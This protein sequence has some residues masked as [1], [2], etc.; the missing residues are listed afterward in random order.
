MLILLG[1]LMEKLPF[2]I[3]KPDGEA[4]LRTKGRFVSIRNWR[5]KTKI[6]RCKAWHES[7]VIPVQ[8]AAGLTKTM[9]PRDSVTVDEYEME[10]YGRF[11]TL[12]DLTDYDYFLFSEFKKNGIPPE[13]WA[14]KAAWY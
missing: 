6:V 12:E 8:T 11:V 3:R 13:K 9:A 14:R 10:P 2:A 1:L 4:V 5:E 7:D